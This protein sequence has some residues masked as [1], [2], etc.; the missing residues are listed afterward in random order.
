MDH[1][2][3]QKLHYKAV[4]S[5][6]LAPKHLFCRSSA[7]TSGSEYAQ[8]VDWGEQMPIGEQ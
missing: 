7:R 2:S 5:G 6:L 4:G 8:L 1:L 3:E